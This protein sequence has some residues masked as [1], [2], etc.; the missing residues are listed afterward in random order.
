MPGF[1]GT[2]PRG[3]GPLTGRGRGYCIKYLG[4]VG[5]CDTMGDR[6]RQRR[7]SAG[8]SPLAGI[9]PGPHAGRNCCN[10]AGAGWQWKYL[11][12]RLL[13][14]NNIQVILRLTALLTGSRSQVQV[15]SIIRSIPGV[16]LALLDSA[17]RQALILVNKSI[18]GPDEIIEKILNSGLMFKRYS[19]KYLQADDCISGGQALFTCGKGPP[20]GY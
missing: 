10:R 16:E 8:L 6:G 12:K 20:G 3:K 14:N 19:L 9:S 4:E 17:S 7:H 11:K 1:S 15:L 18:S 13:K 5:D 2:G